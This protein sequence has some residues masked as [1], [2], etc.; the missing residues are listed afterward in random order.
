MAWPDEKAPAMKLAKRFKR[1]TF[2]KIEDLYNPRESIDVII[3]LVDD[4]D[5]FKEILKSRPV[6]IRIVSYTVFRLFW[7]AI[8]AE[9]RKIKTQLE[10]LN[11][12]IHGIDE[13]ILIISPDME[14]QEIND[15][16]LK[17]NGIF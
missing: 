8:S 12:I 14:V 11:A 13:N 10:Q 5:L 17:K 9:T 4:H 7:D 15:V 3:V 2:T 16:C 1:K 6:N